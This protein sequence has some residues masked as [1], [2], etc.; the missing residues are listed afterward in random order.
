MLRLTKTLKPVPTIFKSNI[1]TSQC[2]SSSHVISV[3]VPKRSHRKL[4]QYRF[5]KKTHLLSQYQKIYFPVKTHI[6]PVVRSLSSRFSVTLFVNT[7]KDQYWHYQCTNALRIEG[8]F[9]KMYV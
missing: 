8:T 1:Q 2:S 5:T 6:Y 4:L 9:L 3:T 7:T